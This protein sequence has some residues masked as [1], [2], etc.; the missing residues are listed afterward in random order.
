M[1]EKVRLCFH[2]IMKSMVYNTITTTERKCRLYY[3]TT[4][5][6]QM[7]LTSWGRRLYKKSTREGRIEKH[8]P[9]SL[10]AWCYGIVIDSCAKGMLQ[11]HFKYDGF[12]MVLP[13]ETGICEGT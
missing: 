4:N 5:N 11:V 2:D 6:M 12:Y 9:E 8:F 3:T 10:S 13:E 1:T 7:R